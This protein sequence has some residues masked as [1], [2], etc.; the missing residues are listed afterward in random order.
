MIGYATAT[1]RLVATNDTTQI[2]GQGFPS[3]CL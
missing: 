2:S 1:Y 3:H